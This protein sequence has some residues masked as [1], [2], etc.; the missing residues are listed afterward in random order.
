MILSV[1]K[2]TSRLATLGELGEFPLHCKALTHTFKYEW[3]IINKSNTESIVYKAYKEMETMVLEGKDCWLSRV[4]KLKT[5]FHIPNIPQHLNFETVGKK[6]SKCVN[7]N[8]EGFWLRS[9]NQIVTNKCTCPLDHNKLR[10]Y[11]QFK[12]SFTPEPYIENVIN[13]NQ[14][15]VLTRFRVSNHRLHIETGRWTVPKT[16]LADRICRYCISGSIDT[17]LHFITECTLTSDNR[18]KCYTL[19]SGFN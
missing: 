16:A 3:H 14:R 4:Y 18:N 10:L 7:S 1:S 9:I 13:R 19:L 11:K 2:Q 15:S 17:E 5:L 6:L 8:F 12:G